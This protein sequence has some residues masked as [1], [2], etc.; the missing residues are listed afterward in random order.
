MS[1]SQRKRL[2]TIAK[3]ATTDA[4]DEDEE[5]EQDE[6]RS[7]VTG[8]DVHL[9][10]TWGVPPSRYQRLKERSRRT[11]CAASGT[12]TDIIDLRLGSPNPYCTFHSE[13]SHILFARITRRIAPKG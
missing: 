12:A 3:K 4:L 5:Q 13:G 10:D 11:Q 7:H 2:E 9:N 6:P 1:E 8:E